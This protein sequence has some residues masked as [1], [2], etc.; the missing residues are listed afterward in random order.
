MWIAR[1]QNG[2]ERYRAERDRETSSIP[3]FRDGNCFHNGQNVLGCVEQ[4]HKDIIGKNLRRTDHFSTDFLS[5]LVERTLVV[6]EARLSARQLLHQMD[7]TLTEAERKTYEDFS[8]HQSPHPTPHERLQTPPEFP[9]DWQY[10]PNGGN[11]HVPRWRSMPAT[12]RTADGYPPLQRY[13]TT[14]KAIPSGQL[15][16]GFPYQNGFKKT[17]NDEDSL[18]EGSLEPVHERTYGNEESLE[19]SGDQS[20]RKTGQLDHGEPPTPFTTSSPSRKA[21][22]PLRPKSVTGI[23]QKAQI[24]D[25]S[26]K[27]KLSSTMSKPKLSVAEAMSQ[28]TDSKGNSLGSARL[29]DHPLLNELNERDQVSFLQDVVFRVLILSS[30]DFSPRYFL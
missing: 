13:P 27:Q 26:I 9:S 6:A 24:K 25:S 12:G 1:G 23:P 3:G 15:S 19:F 2:L 21:T 28:K 8:E 5:K 18:A 10:H 4:I 14:S 30:T 7:K 29:R 22:F 17:W 20:K 11:G 16:R